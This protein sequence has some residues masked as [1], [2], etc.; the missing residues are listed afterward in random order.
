MPKK[1]KVFKQVQVPW[2]DFDWLFQLLALLGRDH[3]AGVTYASSKLA[4]FQSFLES[5][6][7]ACCSAE[8]EML[9]NL[10]IWP[11]FKLL[12]SGSELYSSIRVN[13]SS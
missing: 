5:F 10:P 9:H 4:T 6:L 3:F 11:P 8:L 13:N 2:P 1:T 12:P 7:A